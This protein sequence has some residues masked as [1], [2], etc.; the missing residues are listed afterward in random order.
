MWYLFDRCHPLL[1]CSAAEELPDEV[2]RALGQCQPHRQNNRGALAQIS[3]SI[4]TYQLIGERHLVPR[5]WQTAGMRKS[6][7]PLLLT[8]S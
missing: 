3:S 5:V 6:D 4:W 1:G 8:L 2:C 7:A